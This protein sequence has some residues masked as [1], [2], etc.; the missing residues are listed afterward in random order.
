MFVY[1]SVQRHTTMVNGKK[2]TRVNSVT[3]KNN[4]GVKEVR[5]LGKS[6]RVTRRNK[7]ALTKKEIA[8]IKRCKFIP[9]LFKDCE[10]CL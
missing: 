8:C 10:K 2:K 7:K 9:G 5:Y 4:K 1:S 6:G 3:V